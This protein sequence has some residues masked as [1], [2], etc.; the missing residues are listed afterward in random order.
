[1]TAQSTLAEIRQRSMSRR[2]LGIA[3]LLLPACASVV[4][5]GPEA[6]YDSVSAFDDGSVYS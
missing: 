2:A 5:A 6:R 4:T 3:L 1:M